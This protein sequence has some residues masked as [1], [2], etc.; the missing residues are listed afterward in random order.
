VFAFTLETV[1]GALEDAGARPEFIETIFAKIS[2]R[3]ND[4]WKNEA[5]IRIKEKATS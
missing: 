1:R 3:L 2:K 4:D 5:L